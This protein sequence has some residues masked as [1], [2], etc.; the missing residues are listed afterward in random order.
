MEEDLV[1]RAGLS[2]EGIAA[3][4]LRGRNLA[5]MLGG[6]WTLSRGFR[7][8][9]RLI[10]TFR[11]DVLFVTGGYVCVPVALAARLAGVPALIY[12]PDI[13]PGL[14]IKFLARLADRV[15]VTAPPAAQHFR[16]GQAVVTGYPARRGLFEGDRA[17]A[18][19]RLGLA[20]GVPVILV[21]G[22][23]QGARSINRAVSQG[24]ETMLQAAQVIHISGP[25]D[26][27]WV[28][29]RRAGLP[30]PL[31]ARY[32]VY[33]YLHEEMV[34]A[35]LA[36]DLAVARAGASTLGEFPAVGL[37]A[38]L[39]PYPYAGAHQ[40]AN[41]RYMVE[42]GAAVAV[43]D[44]DLGTALVPTVMSLLIDSAR[45]AALGQ[46]ARGL[47][48]PEAAQRIARELEGLAHDP[49]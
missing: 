27:E 12:L 10:A 8:A 4:G 5:A 24:I 15:A 45:R 38:V 2:F 22:G 31:Q 20:E 29:E 23:S 47:A 33:H 26:S 25:R 30:A 28:R 9:R 21:L 34:D 6:L 18:R 43:A 14:A 17:E 19:A 49:S 42:A 40:W 35:L 1:K 39:V 41:A 16:L 36:A 13:E 3:A 37:P 11:P 44:A 46:A 7:Q 48:Q 32:H